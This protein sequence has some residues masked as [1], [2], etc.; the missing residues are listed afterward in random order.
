MRFRRRDIVRFCAAALTILMASG[1]LLAACERRPPRTPRTMPRESATPAATAAPIAAAPAVRPSPT[2]RAADRADAPAPDTAARQA[3]PSPIARVADRADA[4]APDTAARQAALKARAAEL[5]SRLGDKFHVRYEWPFVVAG[6]IPLRRFNAIFEYSL[7]DSYRCLQRD[8]F[9]TVPTDVITVYL[10]GDD[11]T[12]RRYTLELFDDKP[13]TPFGYYSPS[14]RALI[15][16][17]GT[18]T[19]TL[20]HELC[21]A[22]F[23]YDFPNAP[24]W[25]NE[26]LASLHEQCTHRGESLVGL[27]NWRLPALQKAIR[28][29]KPLPLATLMGKARPASFYDRD[30]GLNYPTARYLC[31]YVQQQGKL[32]EYYALLKRTIDKD[33]TGQKALETVLDAPLATIEPAWQSWVMTLRFPEG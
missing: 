9:A 27:P 7:L 6:N 8:Y 17:I 14:K 21:H 28:A 12:Y 25:F 29:K 23:E 3:A 16:N 26:G 5:Q 11:A 33:P 31:Q 4:P 30:D 24:T 22:L 10:F 1:G 19:G 32:K 18:G 20:V 13:D 15:M 2:A